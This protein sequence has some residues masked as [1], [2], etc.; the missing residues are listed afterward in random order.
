MTFRAEYGM[1]TLQRRGMTSRNPCEATL[2][3]ERLP[4]QPTQS[5]SKVIGNKSATIPLPPRGKVNP[6]VH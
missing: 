3:L 4:A 6:I 5:T 2:V 1:A